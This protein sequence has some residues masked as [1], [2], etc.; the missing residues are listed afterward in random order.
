VQ[1]DNLTECL[2]IDQEG[3]LWVGTPGGLNRLQRKQ[4]FV[5]GQEEGLGYGPVQ[6]LAEDRNG[7]VWVG[8]R[9]RDGRIS[10]FTTRKGPPVNTISQIL[11]DDIGRLWLGSNRGIACVS[12][13]DLDQLAAGAIL[14]TC[15]YRNWPPGSTERHS[16]SVRSSVSRGCSL[17][18]PAIVLVA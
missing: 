14:A 11:E 16:A 17:R 6:S 8:S 2:L 15:Y 13:R 18:L 5:F 1:S 3:V 7:G 4:L 12:K 10:M 9:L